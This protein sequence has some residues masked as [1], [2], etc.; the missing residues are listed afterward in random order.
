MQPGSH[1]LLE[2]AL[3]SIK[4]TPLLVHF[5]SIG[6]VDA[7]KLECV[8]SYNPQTRKY[9]YIMRVDDGEEEQHFGRNGMTLTSFMS[10][11]DGDIHN[12]IEIINPLNRT[13]RVIYT[14]PR[15]TQRHRTI[16]RRRRRN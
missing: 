14:T 12:L 5:I 10:E 13:T 15:N 3:H 2:N 4:N 9:D 16:P 8:L 7:V 6:S 11:G 1:I